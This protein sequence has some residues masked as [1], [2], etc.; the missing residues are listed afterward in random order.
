MKPITRI[1]VPLDFSTH[2][3]EA[4]AWAIDL[5]GHYGAALWLVHTYEPSGVAMPGGYVSLT[6]E[7]LEA[8]R[9]GRERMLIAAQAQAIA[10]G[11]QDVETF[12]VPGQA[13]TEILR[14]ARE[15][16]CGLIVMGTHGRTG[17]P[18]AFFGSVAE[19]VARLAKCPVLTARA[20]E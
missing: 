8:E 12:L 3:N 11:I 20:P 18:H 4:L 10:A 7:L 9:R 17:L 15:N 19:Q 2:S 5:A 14:I 16:D 6:P 13:A 1:L